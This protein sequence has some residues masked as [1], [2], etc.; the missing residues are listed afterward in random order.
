MKLINIVTSALTVFETSISKALK[1]GKID[2]SE[3]NMLQTL[4]SE[5]FNDLSNIG[6][7]MAA[8]TRS[9]FQKSLL[10]GINDLKK[11]LRK[12]NAS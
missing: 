2:E 3:F 9:R 6:S 1:D 5:V 12:R 4:H 7:I 10:E 8:E 11:E